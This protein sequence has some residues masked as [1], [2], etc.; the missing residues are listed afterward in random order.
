VRA[1]GS[2]AAAAASAAAQPEPPPAP[3]VSD[4]EL[5]AL[6]VDGQVWIAKQYAKHK[7]FEGFVAPPLPDDSRR[8][9]IDQW[10]AI[11]AYTG[12]SAMLP[13][14]VTGLAI[15]VAVLLTT[16]IAMAKGFAM[17]AAEQKK[18]AGVPDDVTPNSEA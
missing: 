17:L 9:L 7:V 12:V 8:T 4:E 5:A 11:A 3:T 2:S 18:A 1:A 6:A 14:W 13:P 16:T 10:K 15:P